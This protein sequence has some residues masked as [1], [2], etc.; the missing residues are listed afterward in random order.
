LGADQASAPEGENLYSERRISPVALSSQSAGIASWPDEADARPI[1]N[2]ES[3]MA[4][5][6]SF[7]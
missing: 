6:P 4:M 1:R 5:I 3:P 2:E 7:E